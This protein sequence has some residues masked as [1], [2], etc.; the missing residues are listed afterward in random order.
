MKQVQENVKLKFYSKISENKPFGF[1]LYLD[2]VKNRNRRSYVTRMRCGSHRLNVEIGRWTNIQ[3]LSRKCRF[4]DSGL[5]EDE[6]HVILDCNAF[7]NERQQ[8]F[9][10]IC[11]I[12]PNFQKTNR[13]EK[14]RLI[15]MD[16]LGI[17]MITQKFIAEISMRINEK[18]VS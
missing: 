11:S 3:Q 14:L 8:F 2:R 13:D 4:C 17:P 10:E 6:E 18:Y 15:F 1:K 7:K 5:L 12:M 9:Q 16:E